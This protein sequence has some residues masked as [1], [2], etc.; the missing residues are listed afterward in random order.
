MTIILQRKYFGDNNPE[1]E[2][3]YIPYEESKK[4]KR[5]TDL[6]T[7]GGIGASILGGAGYYGL[8]S[9]GIKKV[10]DQDRR[11]VYNTEL[12][13][14][15]KIREE[16]GNALVDRFNKYNE[17]YNNVSKWNPF[18]GF[19]RK[20]LL[21]NYEN[22]VS[23]IKAAGDIKMNNLVSA[24]TEQMKGIKSRQNRE[25]RGAA[26]KAALIVGA[27]AGLALGARALKRRRDKKKKYYD[28]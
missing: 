10:A 16:Q 12:N 15:F 13:R 27:G 11:S 23:N 25:L 7:A 2:R 19:K 17:D 3:S 14:G 4:R 9:R 24:S 18:K 5:K 26:G 1:N 28:N 8:K 21:K 6:L 20:K 22:D